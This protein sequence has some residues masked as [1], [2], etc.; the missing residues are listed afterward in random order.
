MSEGQFTVVR[1]L[2]EG[3]FGK[4]F[5]IEDKSDPSTKQALKL[6]DIGSMDADTLALTLQ[7]IKLLSE[8]EHEHVLSFVA[9]FVQ[10]DKICIVTEFC[11]NGDLSDYI[12]NQH[13]NPLE[14]LRLI[15]W[16]RQIA[17]AIEYLHDR[18]IIHR[19]LKSQN[20]FLDANMNCKLGDF[21][22]ARVLDP[23]INMAQ[24][25]IGTPHYMS[26]EIF[27]GIGYNAKTDIWSLSIL[28]YE[29]ATLEKPFDA[30]FMP[31][32]IFNITRGEKP[33]MPTQY[34]PE[35]TELLSRMM[36][37]DPNDRPSAREIMQDKLFK[38]RQKPKP[39][40]NI[41]SP[42]D[43]GSE[44]YYDMGAFNIRSALQTIND[45]VPGRKFGDKKPVPKT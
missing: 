30:L 17:S 27:M 32:L 44:D 21:G 35:F 14:E 16:F 1:L 31:M 25:Q 26:P 8:L 3:G 42:D 38:E 40:P 19:D 4:V 33:T 12:N 45:T 5:L 9:S 43:Y 11:P 41:R 36:E 20:I 7:E 15:E 39:M 28:I 2:G 18:N 10:D 22:I 23:V 34:R 29:L 13:G 24:T 6:M 37:K